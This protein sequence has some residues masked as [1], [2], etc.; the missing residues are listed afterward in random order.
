MVKY[1]A[2]WPMPKAAYKNLLAP[3]KRDA[4]KVAKLLDKYGVG[5][6]DAFLAN[7]QEIW[8]ANLAT[9][10]GGNDGPCAIHG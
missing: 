4:I 10:E 3:Q 8:D 7:W 2:G 9:C 5:D 1:S 6:G